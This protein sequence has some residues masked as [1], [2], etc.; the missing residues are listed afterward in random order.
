MASPFFWGIM[1]FFNALQS[2]MFGYLEVFS[3]KKIKFYN[4]AMLPYRGYKVI[5]SPCVFFVIYLPNKKYAE[6]RQKSAKLTVPE[7]R[8]EGD[9]H[10]PPLQLQHLGQFLPFAV[11]WHF[12]GAAAFLLQHI[13]GVVLK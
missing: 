9:G 8:T 13:D 3:R 12:D 6:R 5:T 11:A 10:S 1:F 7:R 2:I 4:I